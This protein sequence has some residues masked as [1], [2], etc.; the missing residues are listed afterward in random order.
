MSKLKYIPDDYTLGD[1]LSKVLDRQVLTKEAPKPSNDERDAC[2]LRCKCLVCC[3]RDS[4]VED[5]AFLKRYEPA[6]LA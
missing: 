4:L 1:L 5:A 6:V 3:I 2:H